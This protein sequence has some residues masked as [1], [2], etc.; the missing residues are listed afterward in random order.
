MTPSDENP[1]NESPEQPAGP[2]GPGPGEETADGISAGADSSAKPVE[3]TDP[4]PLPRP[5][6]RPEKLRTN[7]AAQKAAVR[8]LGKSIGISLPRNRYRVFLGKGAIPPV[9]ETKQFVAPL[10][11][12]NKVRIRILEGDE[13]Q[14]DRNEFLGEIGI[15]GIRLREDGKAELELEFSL[16]ATGI[17]TIRLSDRI[18]EAEGMAR[19]SLS[20]FRKEMHDEVD[21]T[22]MPAEELA[23]KIDLLEQQMQTI[24]GEIEVRREKR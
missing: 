9:S 24:K 11:E 18:G 17:L 20:S 12:I 16:S 3:S 6:E 23:K 1:G 21:I 5:Q 4:P 22:S 14:A 15:N 13:D 7:G 2:Q 10:A 19:F 8:R